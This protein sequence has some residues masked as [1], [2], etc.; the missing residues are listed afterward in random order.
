ML[1]GAGEEALSFELSKN[2]VGE[3]SVLLRPDK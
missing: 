2:D 1:T 3:A